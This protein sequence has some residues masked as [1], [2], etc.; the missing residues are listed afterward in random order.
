MTDKAITG[1]ILDFTKFGKKG[2]IK[3]LPPCENKT[4]GNWYCIAH[5]DWFPHTKQDKGCRV[6]WSCIDHGLEQP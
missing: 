2:S 4:N 1:E 5:D 6:A 3:V